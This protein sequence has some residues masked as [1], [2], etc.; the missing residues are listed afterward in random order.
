MIS[1]NGYRDVEFSPW[2][3]EHDQIRTQTI[4]VRIGRLLFNTSDTEPCVQDCRATDKFYERVFFFFFLSF[5]H[6]SV[7][8]L[9]FQFHNT[10]HTEHQSLS[11]WH[12]LSVLLCYLRVGR[13][14]SMQGRDSVNNCFHR[15]RRFR[16]R[17][18][19]HGQLKSVM[20]TRRRKSLK[21]NPT[22][23]EFPGRY[24]FADPRP[25]GHERVKREGSGDG[26]QQLDR[27]F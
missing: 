20:N 15:A 13:T 3:S 27:A 19:H 4:D 1:H 24:E 16:S 22:N 25:E 5:N 9:L 7:Y 11:F 6:K 12:P 17:S 2:F 26:R 14:I 8:F 21:R 10:H 23:D 18:R